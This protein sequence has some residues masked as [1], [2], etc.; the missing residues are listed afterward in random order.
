[1]FAL[2]VWLHAGALNTMLIMPVAPSECGHM[3]EYW[4]SQTEYVTKAIC[5]GTPLETIPK[6][7]TASGCVPTNDRYDYF[8]CERGYVRF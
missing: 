1:M 5:A 3:R 7:I 2:I 8:Q 4:A 6:A